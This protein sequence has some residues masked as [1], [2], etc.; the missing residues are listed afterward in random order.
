VR[1]RRSS[2]SS[3]VIPAGTHF[4][5]LSWQN[6]YPN[7]SKVIALVYFLC[8]VTI[9]E[10]FENVCR[11]VFGRLLVVVLVGGVHLGRSHVLRLLRVPK[12]SGESGP[13]SNFLILVSN[14]LIHYFA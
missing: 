12:N 14:S 2:A 9:D 11:G 1:L 13:F 7:F 4:S 3:P 10:T 5:G 8:N 6:W